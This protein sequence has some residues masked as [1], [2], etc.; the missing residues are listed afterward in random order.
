MHPVS[1]WRFLLL[2]RLFFPFFRL[3]LVAEDLFS[4]PELELRIDSAIGNFTVAFT[5][6]R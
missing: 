2:L 1:G 4:I 6:S 3:F 5:P